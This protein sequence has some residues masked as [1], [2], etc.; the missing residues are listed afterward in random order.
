MKAKIVAVIDWQTLSV[1]KQE[2][3]NDFHDDLIGPNF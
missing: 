3:A 2:A 1:I